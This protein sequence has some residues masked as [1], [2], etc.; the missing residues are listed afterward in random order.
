MNIRENVLLAPYT[1]FQIGGLARYFVTAVNDS[2]VIDALL[3]A[4]EKKLPYF[5][6]GGGSN[7]L[8]SDEGFAGVVIQMKGDNIFWSDDTQVTADA[9]VSWDA[10]VAESVAHHCFGIENLSGIPGSVGGAAAGNIGAYGSEVKETLAWVEALD[11]NTMSVLRIEKSDC[12]YGYR[13]SIFKHEEGKHLIILRAT[14]SLTVNGVLDHG[15]KDIEAYEKQKGEITTLQ[16]MRS[17]VLEIRGSKFPRD[18]SIGT[19]GSFF[20]NP[21]V[22]TV[23]AEAF[24]LRFPDAPRFPQEDG[25]VKLSAAWIIDKA[26][27]MRGTRVGQVGTLSTQALVLVNYGGAQAKEIKNFSQ[28]I[29][30]KAKNEIGVTLSPEVIFVG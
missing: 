25:T 30:D 1:M 3:F 12:R 6:L 27:N 15:Y 29:I 13:D 28:T 21:V 23:F 14:F 8:V 4:R 26:L 17:A 5:I 16:E 24:H 19:A 22:D 2:D 10:L 18:G 9:G 11:I 20:K 7:I